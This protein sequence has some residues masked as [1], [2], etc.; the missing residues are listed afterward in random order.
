MISAAY[1]RY[2]FW[3][4]IYQNEAYPMRSMNIETGF[5]YGFW[6]LSS[7]YLNTYNPVLLKPYRVAVIPYAESPNIVQGAQYRT[8]RFALVM[9]LY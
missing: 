4:V 7:V 3:H 6:F 2:Q 1:F 8:Y 9:Y 5:L